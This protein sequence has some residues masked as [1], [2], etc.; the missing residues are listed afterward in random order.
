[1]TL[2]D[3]IAGSVLVISALLGLLRGATRELTTVLAF[4]ASL[5]LAFA[6]GPFLAPILARFVKFEWIAR[7]VAILL[8]FIVTYMGLRLLTGALSASV[9][10]GSLAGLDRMLGLGVGLARGVLILALLGVLI[11][12][13]IPTDSLPGWIR[14][15]RLYPITARAGAALRAVAPK[16]LRL[17]RDLV[18][19]EADRH[20]QARPQ[21]VRF[22]GVSPSALRIAPPRLAFVPGTPS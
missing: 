11:A 3:A 9:R 12:A 17:T 18:P 2:F 1:M 6:L 14:Q 16:G 15:A 22:A 21:T 20:A 13:V 5:I 7:T 19:S 8:V 4:T 10:E